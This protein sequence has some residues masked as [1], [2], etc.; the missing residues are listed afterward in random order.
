MIHSRLGPVETSSRAPFGHTQ[1]IDDA[2]TGDTA[3]ASSTFVGANA[4][5]R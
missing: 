4:W 5:V 1:D 3:G 2:G